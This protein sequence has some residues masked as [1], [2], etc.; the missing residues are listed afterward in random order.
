MRGRPTLPEDDMSCTVSLVSNSQR[1]RVGLLRCFSKCASGLYRNE[2]PLSLQNVVCPLP[3]ADVLSSC[4]EDATEPVSPEGT[5]GPT[6]GANSAA[7]PQHHVQQRHHFRGLAGTRR[8]G[9]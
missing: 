1:S 9:C 3:I 7:Q 8:R 4:P 2:L 5:E 6:V